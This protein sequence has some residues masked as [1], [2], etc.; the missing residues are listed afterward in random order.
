MANVKIPDLPSQSAAT[1]LDLLVIVNS[2]ETT[3]SNITRQALLN[4]IVL[5][6]GTESFQLQRADSTTTG[7]NA[8]GLYAVDIQSYRTNANQVAS[9]NYSVVVGYGSRASGTGAV[10]LGKGNV[11]TGNNS[12]SVG[13]ENSATN[14]RAVSLGWNSG[15]AGVASFSTGRLSQATGNNSSALCNESRAI[16]SQSLVGGNQGYALNA[17]SFVMGGQAI[18]AIGDA[19]HSQIV[20]RNFGSLA[21]TGTFNLTIGTNDIQLYG[22]NRVYQIILNWTAVCNV[23]AGVGNPSVGDMIGETQILTYKKVGGT[24]SQVGTTN[25]LHTN[26]DASMAAATLTTSVVGNNIR[27]TFTA[28][29]TTGSNTYRALATLYVSEVA[30]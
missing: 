7:G 18:S 29:T 11:A 3:T 6:D 19:Q 9:G 8:R 4:N 15:A 20:A 10:A 22:T 12:F 14:A 17:N 25:T 28:P 5:P 27:L 16:G 21:S 1:D 13:E 26:S 30:W 2:G 23:S 24:T